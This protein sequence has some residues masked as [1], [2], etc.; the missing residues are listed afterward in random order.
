MLMSIYLFCRNIVTYLY[1]CNQQR[2]F[3]TQGLWGPLLSHIATCYLL[4]R[5]AFVVS[6]PVRSQG[7]FLNLTLW[8]IAILDFISNRRNL[9][10][11]FFTLNGHVVRTVLEPWVLSNI[12]CCK[13][14]PLLQL[15]RCRSYLFYVDELIIMHNAIQSTILLQFI[16]NRNSDPFQCWMLSSTI[17]WFR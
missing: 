8:Q 16:G 1:F 7:R 3:Q 17:S 12:S 15:F 9:P 13:G 6:H 2:V 4:S 11:F 5:I 10:Y 14:P